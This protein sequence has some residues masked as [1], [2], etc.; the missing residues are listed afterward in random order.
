MVLRHPLDWARPMQKV[1]RSAVALKKVLV[2]ALKKVQHVT[3]ALRFVHLATVVGSQVEVVHLSK[4]GHVVAWL[5][6]LTSTCVVCAQ[7]Y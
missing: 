3:V 7:G 4:L 5:A 1:N 2:V 6:S